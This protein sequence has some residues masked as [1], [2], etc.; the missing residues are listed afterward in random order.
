MPKRILAVGSGAREHAL[1]DALA[2]SPQRPELYA[3]PANLGILQAAQ[4]L[5]PTNGSVESIVRAAAQARIDLVVV[6]PEAELEQGIVDLC[7]DAG[8]AAFGPRKSAARIETSKSWAKDVMVR[9]QVPTATYTVC[10]DMEDVESAISPREAVAVK[11]DGIAAGKGVLV[12]QDHAE[13]LEF[14]ERWLRASEGARVVIED[15]LEGPEL[16]LFAFVSGQQVLPLGIARDYKRAYDNNL[17]PNTGGMGAISPVSLPSGFLEDTAD[18]IVRPV[19]RQLVRSGVSYSGMLY[20]GLMLTKNGPHV[21][22][23][24]ARFG[25]P[26]TQVLLPRLN[27]DLLELLEATACGNLDGHVVDL[28]DSHACGVTVA[29]DGYPVSRAKPAVVSLEEPPADTTLFHAGTSTGS[30]GG[31]MATGGRVF[32]AVGI[33]NTAE[34][35]RSRAYD[36]AGSI[37]FNGAWFRGDIGK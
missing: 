6:G 8:I 11:A 34:L 14:A 15:A 2:R 20:A 26:E 17:G 30:T 37:R 5:T 4:L 9:S 22:E 12:T 13:A 10:R 27:S 19:A 21:I 18:R 31:L 7:L 24:N 16:S 3:Y 35:A 33:G 1:V 36:L 29:S 23:F 28:S 25:D 32:T